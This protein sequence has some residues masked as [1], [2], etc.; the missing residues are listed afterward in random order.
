MKD[1]E[2]I[3]EL[4]QALQAAASE[5]RFVS[6]VLSH[7]RKGEAERPA[8][9]SVRPVRVSGQTLW[10]WTWRTGTQDVHE[11]LTVE[12]SLRR[13]GM[14]FPDPYRDAH[15]FLT[16][17]EWTARS[18]RKGNLH[19]ARRSV[20]RPPSKAEHNR[21][22]RRIIPEG[23]A[24]P[25]LEAIGVMTPS[26]QVRAKK[27]HKFRQINRFLEF[28]EDIVPA[29]PSE[30][31]L[32]VIDYGCGKSGLTF[33][34]HHLLT[35]VHGR[36]VHMIGL[37]RNRQVLQTCEEIA[38]NLKLRGLE[39]HHGDIAEFPGTS[40]VH[41]A[42][43]LHACDTATDAALAKAVQ[44]ETDVILSVPCCQHELAPQL[45]SE[46]LA[47]ILEHGLLR[48]RVATIATDAMRAVLLE[49]SGYS[50]Q[51][52]EFIELEH[53]PKNILIR[54]VKSPR[55][56]DDA[57]CRRLWHRYESLK[58]VLGVK[59]FRLEE[60]LYPEAHGRSASE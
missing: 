52:L 35:T 36:T 5:N 58:R 49:L 9:Y 57:S 12:D 47:A 23:I 42:V 1:H 56:V 28:V 59:E 32:N 4:K 37:D 24:C 26:G 25:F 2:T 15:I 6:L 41:L 55:T 13:F 27:R 39:F 51:V 19:V 43:S 40:P 22:K 7:P 3:D 29:L 34:L 20:S 30:G 11:N 48:D 50:T 31:P 16:D 46:E 33:A 44:L 54:G 38:S 53:T 17:Q 18:S 10:Q 21:T 8:R 45:H 14:L 60:L